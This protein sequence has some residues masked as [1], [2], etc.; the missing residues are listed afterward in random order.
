MDINLLFI[1]KI[2]KPQRVGIRSSPLARSTL[3]RPTHYTQVHEMTESTAMS[4]QATVTQP[5]AKLG[6]QHKRSQV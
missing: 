4:D 6:G 3:P 1:V 2:L 5:S